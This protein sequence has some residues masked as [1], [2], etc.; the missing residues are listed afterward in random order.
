MI[1]L[2]HRALFA[3]DQGM[4]DWLHEYKLMGNYQLRGD[5]CACDQTETQQV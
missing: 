5:V 4:K 3:Y 1:Q 2:Q